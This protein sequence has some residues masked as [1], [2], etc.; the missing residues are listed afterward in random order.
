MR[1]IINILLS[2][3]KNQLNQTIIKLFI[4]FYQYQFVTSRSHVVSFIEFFKVKGFTCWYLSPHLAKWLYKV[5]W[6]QLQS[7]FW[8]DIV[9]AE[10][11]DFP[12]SNSE[13]ISQ[14]GFEPG[15]PS[16]FPQHWLLGQFCMSLNL[17]IFIYIF[18]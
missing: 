10:L 8:S 1:L 3:S 4:H 9:K 14:P 12:M 16:P 7:T 17:Y 18:L 5:A 6:Y 15:W 2:I 11:H 13:A